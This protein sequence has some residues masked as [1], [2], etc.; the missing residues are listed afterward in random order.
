MSRLYVGN[1]SFNT[2]SESLRAA[3]AADGRQ[4][5]EVS[6]VTD[7]ETGR[8]RGFA[9]VEMQSKADAEKAIKALDG[10]SL[11]GRQIKVNEAQERQ[12]RTGGGGGGGQRRDG[13]G[14]GG[15]GRW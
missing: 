14:G 7:R 6:I 5:K 3:M 13:G 4:V 15:G 10:T 1:L 2:T 11:D 8:H 12:P 9:F